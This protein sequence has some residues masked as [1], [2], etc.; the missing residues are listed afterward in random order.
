MGI[1]IELSPVV[2]LAMEVIAGAWGNGAERKEK[3]EAAGYDYKRIQGCVDKL[4]KIIN[5]YGG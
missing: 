3:L 1:M 2:A 5:E 4:M